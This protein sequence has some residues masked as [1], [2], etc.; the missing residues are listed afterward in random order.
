MKTVGFIGLNDPY[1]ENWYKVF[2][3]LAARRH[4]AIVANE[5]LS[6]A[7]TVRVTGQALK[8]LAAKPDAVLVAAPGGASVLPET[9]L[10]DLGYRGAFYQTHGAALPDFLKLGGKQGGR[11]HPGRPA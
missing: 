8:L 1:G 4:I 7:R 5:R 3:G 9:T 2:A 10:V 11:H 6:S